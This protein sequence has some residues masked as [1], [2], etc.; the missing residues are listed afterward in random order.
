VTHRCTR[1]QRAD[2]RGQVI[3]LIVVLTL[4]FIAIAGLVDD[5]GRALTARTRAL[6]EA[7][8]AARAGAQQIDLVL[9]RENGVIVLDAGAAAR[10]A[11]TYLSTTG[12]SGTATVTGD[13]VRVTVRV[14]MPTQI[15]GAFGVRTL[16]VSA[17]AVASA[18]AGT[19][20]NS[21]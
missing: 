6:D 1:P 8:A 14:S 21:T 2:E 4:G 9:L 7:Q 20:R 13:I 3:A 11:E 12:D 10:A 19:S 5:G 15:L 17:D 18:E 16:S